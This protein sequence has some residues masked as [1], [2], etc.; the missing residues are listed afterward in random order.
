MM[1]PRGSVGP[2]L[3]DSA[4]PYLGVLAVGLVLDRFVAYLWPEATLV[5]GQSP[6]IVLVGAFFLASAVLWLLVQGR[7]RIRGPVAWFLIAMSVAWAVHLVIFRVHGDL[8]NHTAWLYVPILL[9]IWFKPP[10]ANEGWAALTALG[11]ATAIVLVGTRLLEIVGV[12]DIMY[13]PQWIIE[14]DKANYWLPLSGHLGLDG[15]WPGPFGHN[16]VTALMGA[17][18][19]VL[20]VARWTRSSPVF[21]IVGALTLLHTGG[22]SSVGAAVV[23]IAV[24]LVFARKGPVAR[25]PYWVRVAA[26]GV[27]V[28]LVGFAM[29]AGDAGLT[30]RQTFWPAFMELWTTSM[31]TGVGGTGIAASGGITAEFGHAH[32]LYVDELARN[33]ILGFGTQFAALG[34]GVYILVRAATRGLAGPLAI[35]ATYAITGLTEPRNDWIHPSITAYLVVV[36][37][38]IA[39]VWTT[40]SAVAAP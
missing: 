17:I 23:G 30:G 19:V 4:A 39:G 22:R 32:S 2:S 28:V 3:R 20:A 9:M 5:K 1:W 16:G 25:I 8:F 34:I 26:G 36:I 10:R 13:V 7:E 18:L 31:W 38:V 21:L 14:F 12:I 27:V 15:R 29:F 40:Q 35:M 37:V 11:W 33:G 24:V 6:A